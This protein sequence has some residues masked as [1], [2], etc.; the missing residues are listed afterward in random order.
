MFIPV[1][2]PFF[3]SP[4]V[5]LQHS[6]PLTRAHT[7]ILSPS[8]PLSPSLSLSLVSL[9]IIYFTLSHTLSASHMQQLATTVTSIKGT[10]GTNGYERQAG[11]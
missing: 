6:T 1:F 3:F 10:K 2:P 7:H 9:P 8:L 11:S 4:T 5:L